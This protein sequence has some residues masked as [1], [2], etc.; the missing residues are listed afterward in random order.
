[1]IAPIGA[2]M[3]LGGMAFDGYG[4]MQGLDAMRGVWEAARERQRAYDQAINQRTQDALAQIN[5]QSVTGAEQ[6]ADMLGRIMGSNKN[7]LR[8]LKAAGGRRPG[9]AEGNA[10]AAQATSGMQGRLIDQAQLAAILHGLRSGGQNYDML[11]RQLGLDTSIIRSDARDAASLVPLQER[12]AGMEGQWARQLGSL[13]NMGGQG[14]MMAGM[15][16]PGAVATPGS[17]LDGASY[18]RAGFSEAPINGW[19]S[20]PIN[21]LS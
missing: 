14:A 6:S 4:Q 13:F 2:A 15:A 7:I 11:G 17:T 3:Q 10:V 5:P 16:M 21:G 1:M 12:A 8:A 18:S 9:N 19:S 20:N